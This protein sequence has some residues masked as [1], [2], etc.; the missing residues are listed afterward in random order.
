MGF[1]EW[2]DPQEE[3]GRHPA[4]GQNIKSL[5]L[6]PFR[7]VCALAPV[8]FLGSEVSTVR[9]E[10]GPQSPVHLLSA[11][12]LTIYLK[13][14]EVG[15]SKLHD[16]STDTADNCSAFRDY[17]VVRALQGKWEKARAE[18]NIL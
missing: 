11:W 5:E 9:V 4:Q 6:A 2:E 12:P 10:A 17:F 8:S 14:L 15:H 1:K 7:K 3:S 18:L 16:I 13:T